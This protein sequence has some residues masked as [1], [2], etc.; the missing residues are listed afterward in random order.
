MPATLTPPDWVDVQPR[1]FATSDPSGRAAMVVVDLTV[2]LPLLSSCVQPGPRKI[3]PHTTTPGPSTRGHFTQPTSPDTP[4]PTRPT[5]QGQCTDVRLC[6]SRQRPPRSG[7]PVRRCVLHLLPPR[8]QCRL[9]DSGTPLSSGGGEGGRSVRVG[10]GLWLVRRA[11]CGGWVGHAGLKS[12]P[13]VPSRA[14]YQAGVVDEGPV[15]G[16]G[17]AS[18]HNAAGFLRGL[19]LGDLPE[20]AALGRWCRGGSG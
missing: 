3:S 20:V 5:A 4:Y 16:V 17:D 8:R 13:P 10:S 12:R 18:F 9:E 15:N 11:D 19:S 7:P 14:R 6:R 1:R 2:R